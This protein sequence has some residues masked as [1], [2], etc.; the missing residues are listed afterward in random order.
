VAN[1]TEIYFLTSG[2]HS[3]TMEPDDVKKT[4]SHD[5]VLVA[6]DGDIYGG[7]RRFDDHGQKLLAG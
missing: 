2:K 1:L 3:T 5:F 4:P 6:A 7:P